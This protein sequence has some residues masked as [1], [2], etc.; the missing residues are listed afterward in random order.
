[1]KRS[2]FAAAILA[3]AI[4]PVFAQTLPAVPAAPAAVSS[5]NVDIDAVAQ[6]VRKSLVLVE[7]RYEDENTPRE[8]IGHGI[9][10]SP[11]TVLVWGGLI[12]ES[13]PKD[14]VKSIKIR[15]PGKNFTTVKATLLGRTQNRLFSYI[16]AEKPLD[17]PALDIS[18]SAPVKLGQSVFSVSMYD[19]AVGYDV[20]VGL[21]EVRIIQTRTYTLAGVANFSLT[22]P[23]SPVFDTA[24]GA[25]VG[26]TAPSAGEDFYI[27][28]PAAARAGVPELRRV[29]LYDEN[30]S[31]AFLIWSEVGE[32]FGKVPTAPFDLPR[33]WAG[34][35]GLAGLDE[36]ERDFHKIES[37]SGVTIGSIVPGEPAEKAGLLPRDI[38]LTINGRA[39]SDSPVPAVMQT[40]FQ[41]EMDR[42]K[43]GESL[44]FGILRDDKKMDIAVKLGASPKIGSE[45]PHV[46]DKKVGVVTRDLNF[47][48]IYNRK[49]GTDTKGVMIALVKNGAP[50]SLGQTPLRAGLIITKVNDTPVENQKQFA[51]TLK[52]ETD[53]PEKK[54]LVFVALQGDGESK[55]F[56]VELTK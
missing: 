36:N 51:E 3:G 30:Q 2:L 23:N 15:L 31:S 33:P 22:R 50:A 17:A 55:V 42:H 41:R 43:P 4:S 28:D 8:E 54:E 13:I 18:K 37:I 16:K 21:S 12:S 19:K 39:F 49:L 5:G 52:K 35:G 45:L 47:W 46:F 32:F 40:H 6:K 48:D 29:Q 24:T 26:I 9:V 56:R 25:L 38:I 20:A 34:L 11:D 10:V 27:R 7:W 14:Y 53:D 44:V 1:M